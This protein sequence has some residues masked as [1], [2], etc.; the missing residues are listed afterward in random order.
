MRF[1]FQI[2]YRP[3]ADGSIPQPRTVSCD[4][5]H[6][7]GDILLLFEEVTPSVITPG[8]SKGELRPCMFINMR[9][10]RNIT[11]VDA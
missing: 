1:T 11:R 10:V 3:D 5:T 7:S 8:P 4:Q 6:L 9:D 2:E